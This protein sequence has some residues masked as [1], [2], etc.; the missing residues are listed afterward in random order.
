MVAKRPVI[1]ILSAILK[2]MHL[3][4]FYIKNKISYKNGVM[5]EIR[6]RALG[7]GIGY[8]DKTKIM[9]RGNKVKCRKRVYGCQ[10]CVSNRVEVSISV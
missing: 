1:Y 4:F 9:N 7:L 8:M 2:K 5:F 10:E 3:N 6:S